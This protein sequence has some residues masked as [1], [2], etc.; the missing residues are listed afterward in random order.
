[1]A[2]RIDAAPQGAGRALTGACGYNDA[3][4]PPE[5]L[6]FVVTVARPQRGGAGRAE[7]TR[8]PRGGGGAS[9]RGRLREGTGSVA[10]PRLDVRAARLDVLVRPAFASR[11]VQEH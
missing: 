3:D 1:M 4:V 5:L 2:T 10:H 8:L 6:R 9:R 7:P 11:L